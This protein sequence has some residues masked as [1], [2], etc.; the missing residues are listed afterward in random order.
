[1][2]KISRGNRLSLARRYGFGVQFSIEVY[3]PTNKLIR[4]KGKVARHAT[5]VKVNE[6]IKEFKKKI[7]GMGGEVL[8]SQNV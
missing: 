5:V 8:V 1:M 3:V 7:E 4:Y 2:A 6:A